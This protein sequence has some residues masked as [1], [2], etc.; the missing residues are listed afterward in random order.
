MPNE[1]T[2][3]VT[4]EQWQLE[5]IERIIRTAAFQRAAQKRP[6]TLTIDGIPIPTEEVEPQ[7]KRA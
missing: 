5:A 4:G 2:V 7:R 6:I 1:M 3:V